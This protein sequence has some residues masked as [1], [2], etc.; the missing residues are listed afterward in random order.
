MQA[1][2]LCVV[3]YLIFD[4]IKILAAAAVVVPIKKMLRRMKQ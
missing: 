3:P 4:L 2:L 1:L